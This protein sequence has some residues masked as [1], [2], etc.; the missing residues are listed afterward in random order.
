MKGG[1]HLTK[2][3]SNSRELLA[4]IPKDERAKEVKDLDLDKLPIERALGIQWSAESD[5]FYFK[6]VIKERPLTRRGILSV[7]SSIYD[8][9]GLLSPVILPVKVILQEL[10][11]LK[12]GWDDTI[13][14]EYQ[15]AWLRWLEDLPKLSQL[16][17]P[18][19]YKPSDFEVKS[20]E[21]HQFS[22]ASES[23]YGSVSYLRQESHDERIIVHLCLGR[24]A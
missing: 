21:L 1:F 10:C 2:W 3:T 9:L 11:R 8:P 4:S 13:P 7:M 18:C 15:S 5:E 14:D 12:L 24:L 22:D 6:I 23:G 16:S 17:I 20:S 19:C